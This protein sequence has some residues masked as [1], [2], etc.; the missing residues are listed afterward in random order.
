MAKILVVDDEEGVRSLLKRLLGLHNHAVDTANDGAEAIDQ[1]Q[2]KNYDLM[3]IDHRMPKITGPQAVEII[4]SSGKFKALRVLMLTG[5]SFTKDVDAAYEL[6][7]LGYLLK[8]INVQRLLQKVE[9][10]L[11]VCP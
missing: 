5:V 2:R 10:A 3:I 11:F 8:P 4:R 6:G 7:I 9:G 1:L